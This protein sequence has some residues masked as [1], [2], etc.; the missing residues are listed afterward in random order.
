METEQVPIDQILKFQ[1]D[2]IDGHVIYKGLA[3]I[4]RDPADSKIIS[5]CESE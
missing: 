4:V 2:E 3:K 1:Q 5:G